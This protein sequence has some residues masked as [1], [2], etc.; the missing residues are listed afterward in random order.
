MSRHRVIGIVRPAWHVLP[1]PFPSD[2]MSKVANPLHVRT[3]MG[4][5]RLFGVP[6]IGSM[7][8]ARIAGRTEASR[9]SKKTAMAANVRT[10]GSKGLT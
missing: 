6:R 8:A 10:S 7:E 4:W 3:R 9:A 2:A 5:S 1:C